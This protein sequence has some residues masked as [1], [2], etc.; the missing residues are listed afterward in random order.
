[1]YNDFI[2]IGLPYAALFLFVVGSVIRYRTKPFSVSSLS[3]QLLESRIL[4]WGSH[5]FH[6]GIVTLFFGHLIGFLFPKSVI[7]FTGHPTR[8]LIIEISALAFGLLSLFGI[9]TLIYR[10]LAFE[11]LKNITSKMDIVVYVLILTQVISGLWIAYFDRWGS[12]WFA[13]SLAPY[14]KSIF[15]FSPKYEA[16]AAMP[17]SIKLHITSAFIFV[18]MVPFTRLMHFLVYPFVYIIRAYQFVIWNWDR[19]T[20]RSSTDFNRGVKARNN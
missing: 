19:K 12:A 18:G 13:V 15:L 7:S 11:R 4:Y 17:L 5:A 8:L 16:V 3:S 2:F 6:I 1:M 10:R 20:R 9:V 14:L